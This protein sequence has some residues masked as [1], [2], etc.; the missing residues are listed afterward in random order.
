V[1]EAVTK[2]GV[3]MPVLHQFRLALEALH[4]V[5]TRYRWQPF[6]T[7][8]W[9]VNC[10][11]AGGWNE[12]CRQALR[13]RCTHILVINDDV[14]LS[15]WT[16]DALVD[17]LERT[18]IGLVSGVTVNSEPVPPGDSGARDSIRQVPR[19]EVAQ[20]ADNPNFS[21]FM[22][23]PGTL[24]HVGW[25]DEHFFPAF[26]ED[27]DYLYR[28]G[29]SGLL[30]R[31]TTAAPFLHYSQATSQ[32]AVS[33]GQFDANRMYYQRKWGGLPYS[34]QYRQPFGDPEKTWRDI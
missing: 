12:G 25:F 23:T 21:C 4:S 24:A 28:V 20:L 11:V 8:N 5:Q 32:G 13:S 15:P 10:G 26:F 2:V 7:D 1:A 31:S 3:V 9:S 19:P 14:V 30:A 22:V 29:L 27:N 6:I 17:L 16:V 18:E 34:E 33:G